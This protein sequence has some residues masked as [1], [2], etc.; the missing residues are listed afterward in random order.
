L[1]TKY[2]ILEIEG[3]PKIKFHE[4]NLAPEQFYSIDNELEKVCDSQ[5]SEVFFK[6]LIN[7]LIIEPKFSTREINDFNK[8]QL[9][10]LV[11]FITKRLNIGYAICEI[12]DELSPKERLL[13]AFKSSY[14]LLFFARGKD[15]EQSKANLQSWIKRVNEYHNNLDSQISQLLKDAGFWMSP[16]LSS[17]FIGFIQGK[18]SKEGISV[19]TTR[20]AIREFFRNNDYFQL[21]NLVSLWLKYPPFSKREKIISDAL[22][23]HIEGKYTLSIPALLPHVEGIAT[24]LYGSE[25]DLHVGNKNEYYK[26]IIGDNLQYTYYPKSKIDNFLEGYFPQI[27]KNI[28]NEMND[29]P[30]WMKSHHLIENQTLQRHAIMHGGF[31][32]YYSEENSIRVFL[33]LDL[34]I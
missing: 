6:R 26:K 16:N 10:S 18:I 12:S 23:S 25:S 33:F 7:L 19:E 5:R 22:N 1:K 2:S 17:Y 20:K 29:V 31:Y 15:E 32:E 30:A 4:E 11:F 21:R 14:A 34:L 9:L 27:Y 13:E 28:G 24:E 8:Q 3:L